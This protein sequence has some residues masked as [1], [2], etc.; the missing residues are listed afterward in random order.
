LKREKRERERE[1][2]DGPAD[3]VVPV[4]ERSHVEIAEA[5][6]FQPFPYVAFL[7]GDLRC[8]DGDGDRALGNGSAFRLLRHNI[9]TVEA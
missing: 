9:F 3:I 6:V 4:E 1:S 7:D 5:R 8:K 2:E